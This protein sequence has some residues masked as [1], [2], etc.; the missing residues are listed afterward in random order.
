ML[1]VTPDYGFVQPTVLVLVNIRIPSGIN[2]SGRRQYKL[3]LTMAPIMTPLSNS[4]SDEIY[5]SG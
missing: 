2:V 4:T 1:V 5:R 3:I